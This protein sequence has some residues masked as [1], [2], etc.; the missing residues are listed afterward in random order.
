[1]PASGWDGGEP[2]AHF[3]G[4]DAHAEHARIRRRTAGGPWY[5]PQFYPDIHDPSAGYWGATP[6][7]LPNVVV[8]A[9]LT[10]SGIDARMR[11]GGTITVDVVDQ[12]AAP[13]PGLCVDALPAN[14]STPDPR[15]GLIDNSATAVSDVDGRAVLRGLA[16]AS[17]RVKVRKC[18][19]SAPTHADLPRYQYSN[20]A[21]LQDQAT[22]FAVPLSG[23]VAVPVTMAAAAVLTGVV[24]AEGQPVA[25]RCVRW[26][27]DNEFGGG[28]SDITTSTDASG[29][30]RL[31]G[32][33]PTAGRLGACGDAGAYGIGATA[34]LWYPAGANRRTA[35]TIAL[36]PGASLTID[37]ALQR[38]RTISAVVSRVPA[39]RTCQVVMTAGGTRHVIPLR[40]GNVSGEWFG[41][42]FGHEFAPDWNVSQFHL[43]CDGRRA[44]VAR[45]NEFPNMSLVFPT[46]TEDVNWPVLHFL[47]DE[48]G[49]VIRPSVNAATMAWTRS[50]VTVSFSCTD[51]GIGVRSCP[52]AVR[53]AEGQSANVTATDLN[54]NVT[55]QRVGPLR[56]D[57]TPP[58]VTVASRQRTFRTSEV[59]SLGC[60]VRDDRS[61]LRSQ[62]NQCPRAGTKA[63]TLGVGEHRFSVVGT[64]HAGNS[65]WEIVT[66]TVV[67]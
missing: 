54:G 32:L 57:S 59:I 15:I 63:S 53:F 14:G 37:F 25:D 13:R 12:S 7:R 20:G 10:T 9:G 6:A 29:R 33:A 39:G 35:S 65:V 55:T 44:G 17:Y 23:S 41:D 40:P 50:P 61:G 38:E 19:P 46:S 34:P 28:W 18:D 31:E 45:P 43:E 60:S 24:T 58:R 5:A 52:S 67:K 62:T 48:T 2:V 64:D 56:V 36:Q 3:D 8:R 16:P 4:H 22:A 21:Y 51:A 42:R 66:V 49:P 11:P 47:F 26:M 30:Y 27:V 1:M